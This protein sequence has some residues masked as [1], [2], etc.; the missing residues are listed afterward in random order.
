[1]TE[2]AYQ[3]DRERRQNWF[4]AMTHYLRSKQ[5]KEQ[6]GEKGPFKQITI[7]GVKNTIKVVD[8]ETTRFDQLSREDRWSKIK[9]NEKDAHVHI[10][11]QDPS[12][13]T[14][15]E[16]PTITSNPVE[17]I[18]QISVA[19]GDVEEEHPREKISNLKLNEE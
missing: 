2:H 11:V 12:D 7:V 15:V 10:T 3:D 17:P 9:F 19:D 18:Q 4:T 6:L 5:M 14:D 13:P 8:N 16:L 1:M